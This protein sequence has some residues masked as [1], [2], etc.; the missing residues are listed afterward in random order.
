MRLRDGLEGESTLPL[1]KAILLDK[2]TQLKYAQFRSVETRK[3]NYHGVST[4]TQSRLRTSIV[5]VD[6][7]TVRR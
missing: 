7:E 1:V 5:R 4:V 3:G 2:H 6:A